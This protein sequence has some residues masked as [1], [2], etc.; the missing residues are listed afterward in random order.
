[1]SSGEDKAELLDTADRIRE[2]LD[3][4]ERSHPDWDPVRVAALVESGLTAAQRHRYLTLLLAD[5]VRQLRRNRVHAIEA[6]AERAAEQERRAA[7]RAARQAEWEAQAPA[8]EA[9]EAERQAYLDAHPWEARRNSRRFKDWAATPDGQAFLSRERAEQE[10]EE[11]KRAEIEQFGVDGWFR[12]E[13]GRITEKFRQEVRL[14]I[15]EELLAAEFALGDGRMVTWGA[16]TVAEHTQRMDL[17]LGNAHGNLE[18]ARRHQAAVQ[19]ISEAGVA[20]LAEIPQE[21]AA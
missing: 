17:L 16:A 6:R 11:A 1:M 20:T 4:A 8:R 10:K 2:L 19:M 5:E 21:A 12:R 3:T 9:A 13:V 18:T 15:T 7:E 14:E